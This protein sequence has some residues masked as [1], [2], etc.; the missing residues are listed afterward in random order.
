LGEGWNPQT[1]YGIVNAAAAV[2]LARRFDTLEPQVQTAVTRGPKKLSIRLDATEVAREG[3][4]V[5]GGVTVTVE[6]S[7]DGVSFEPWIPE[8]A[9]P[10]GRTI[11]ASRT[12]PAYWFRAVT[13]DAHRNCSVTTSGPTRPQRIKPRVTLRTRKLADGQGRAI[14]SLKRVKG[15]KGRAKVMLERRVGRRYKTIARFRVG[16]GKT[17]KRPIKI[18]PGQPIKLRVRVQSTPD[19]RGVRSRTVAIASPAAP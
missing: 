19:W 10:L 3:E 2:D 16:F 12:G 17:V 4:E 13:C 5:A 18:V 14:V 11:K 15:F 1:G 6:R 7:R 9:T 8:Q